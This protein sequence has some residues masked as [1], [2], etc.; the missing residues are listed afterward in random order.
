MMWL[1]KLLFKYIFNKKEVDSLMINL[2]VMQITLGW[3]T[4]EQVPEPFKA[5]V[6]ELLDLANTGNE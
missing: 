2:F 6:Q 1:I 5:K 4:M 3:I